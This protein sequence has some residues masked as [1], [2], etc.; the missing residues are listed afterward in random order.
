MTGWGPGCVAGVCRCWARACRRFILGLL[1]VAQ[2]TIF[3]PEVGV[4]LAHLLESGPE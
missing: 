4:I 1:L 3:R 2:T